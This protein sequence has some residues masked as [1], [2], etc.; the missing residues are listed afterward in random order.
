MLLWPLAGSYG[1][2]CYG[3][4]SIA[5][6]LIAMHVVQNGW[7]RE[8]FQAMFGVA[9]VCMAVAGPADWWLFFQ[10]GNESIQQASP[11]NRMYIF[12]TELVAFAVICGVIEGRRHTGFFGCCSVT[13]CCAETGCCGLTKNPKYRGMGGAERFKKTLLYRF[14]KRFGMVSFTIYHTESNVRNLT[15]FLL[16]EL[17]GR[18]PPFCVGNFLQDTECYAAKTEC[19]SPQTPELCAKCEAGEQIREGYGPGTISTVPVGLLYVGCVI[20]FWGIGL[21]QWEKFGFVGSFEWGMQKVLSATRKAKSNVLSASTHDEKPFV[22]GSKGPAGEAEGGGGEEWRQDIPFG[23]MCPCSFCGR[24]GSGGGGE[25]SEAE[26]SG[27]G[28]HS[29]QTPP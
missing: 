26:M 5:G 25:Q 14:Y 22:A 3:A 4:E 9:F 28:L 1:F 13:A 8:L 12:A 6:Y 16:G 24:C 29:E 2:F 18:A 21:W 27:G 23:E 11:I 20:A 17:G 19:V 10:D 7:T 15:S